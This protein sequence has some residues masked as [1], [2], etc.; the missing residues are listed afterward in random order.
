MRIRSSVFT[1]H[2]EWVRILRICLLTLSL[3]IVAA[4]SDDDES[5][6]T[7]GVSEVNPPRVLR[8]RALHC[9]S[10]RGRSGRTDRGAGHGRDGFRAGDVHWMR[11][12]P[13]A[14]I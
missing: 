10:T 5:P 7:A 4:C 13:F 3:T 1:P 6:L 9:G 12:A 2:C 14:W 8:A 11:R